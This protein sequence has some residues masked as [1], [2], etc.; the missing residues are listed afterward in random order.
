MTLLK[1]GLHCHDAP[2]LERT[3][4]HLAIVHPD[5]QYV[6]YG[7]GA[8]QAASAIR[9]SADDQFRKAGVDDGVWRPWVTVRGQLPDGGMLPEPFNSLCLEIHPDFTWQGYILLVGRV[10]ADGSLTPRRGIG[11]ASGS[12]YRENAIAAAW[13]NQHSGSL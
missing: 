2:E 13:N 6:D 10:G 4:R 5:A 12:V 7:A 3:I 1:R 8:I 11:V 9:Q